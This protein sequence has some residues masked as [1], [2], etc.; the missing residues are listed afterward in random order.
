MN[1]PLAVIRTGGLGMSRMNFLPVFFGTLGCLLWCSCGTRSLTGGTS[2]AEDA[3]VAGVVYNEQGEPVSGARV[4][5]RTSDY[6]ADTAGI[7]TGRDTVTDENGAFRIDSVVPG[8]YR[9]EVNDGA[10]HAALLAC[11]VAE[12]DTLVRIPDDT[13][14]PTGAIRGMVTPISDSLVSLYIQVPGLER[15]GVRDPETGTFVIDDLPRGSYTIRMLASSPDFHLVKFDSASVVSG[16]VSD[17]GVID[18]NQAGRWPYSKV[19]VL[20]TSPS[21]ANVSEAVVDFPVLVRLHK[22]NFDFTAANADGSDIR[23][24][25]ADGSALPYEIERWDPVAGRAEVW[26]KI[27]TVR[28]NDS[29]QTVTMV[30]GNPAAGSASAGRSVFDTATGFRGVWHLGES[31]GLNRDATVNGYNGTR[32]GNQTQ[33][34]GIIGF[35]QHLDGSGDYAEMGDVCN[36][37]DSAFTVCMWIKRAVAD[38]RTTIIS[39]SAGGSPSSSY[40]W[41]LEIDPDGVMILFL[42][43]NSGG[44]GDSGTLVLASDT[45]I[46]DTGW[47]YVAAVF[48]RSGKDKSRLYFDGT[49]VSLLPT[50]GDAAALGTVVNH[51]PLRLGA[52]A[53]GGNPWN[54][55]LDECSISFRAR[56]ADW[57]RLCFMNQ[58]R[59]DQLIVV[60]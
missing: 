12:N 9:V 25:K 52:D 56:S 23:F 8:S 54:G 38:V 19:I 5:L 37:D 46:A 6:T 41:L 28:G 2:T 60:R 4:Q 14:Y 42:S 53:N 44:W 30:W 31:S 34:G 48:D 21:G 45:R 36:P 24:M 51:A 22:D 59:D 18:V 20:N 3:R 15:L 47:H 55:V 13:L 57:I 32:N 11:D 26:V 17:I 50:G 1:F 27:D 40:G 58:Q 43:T 16:R 35:G 39:K 33:G 7:T 10:S 49:D 29:T